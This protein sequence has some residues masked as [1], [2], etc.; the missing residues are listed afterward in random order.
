MK[1]YLMLRRS[2]RGS[3][4]ICDSRLVTS[5]RCTSRFSTWT[6]ESINY[7]SVPQASTMCSSGTG[8]N[9]SSHCTATRFWALL[10]SY[11]SASPWPLAAGRHGR[12]TNVSSWRHSSRRLRYSCNGR[13]SRYHWQQMCRSAYS[14][15]IQGRI[16]A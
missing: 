1:S 9:Q 14:A 4:S 8:C 5:R 3:F 7:P 10:H 6:P 13:S 16:A 2:C 12:S 15:W 11:K